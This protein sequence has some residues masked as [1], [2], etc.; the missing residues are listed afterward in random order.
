MYTID[1]CLGIFLRHAVHFTSGSH[2]LRHCLIGQKHEIL[3]KPIGFLGNLL[4]Y[5]YRLTLRIDLN[6]HL[7]T[8]KINGSGLPPL[9]PHY[10]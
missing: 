5:P 7:G 10:G 6:L 4:I 9:S 8:V 2:K 3:N 1:K